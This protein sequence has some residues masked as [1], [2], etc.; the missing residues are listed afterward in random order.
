MHLVVVDL[1]FEIVVEDMEEGCLTDASLTP[2]TDYVGVTLLKEIMEQSQ[3]GLQSK[4]L[5][6]G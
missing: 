3:H 6:L 1:L 2:H 5:D 4:R